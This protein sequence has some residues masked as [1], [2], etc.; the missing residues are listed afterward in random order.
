M[1]QERSLLRVILTEK[2]LTIS[3]GDHSNQGLILDGF[4]VCPVRDQ[5]KS[6]LDRSKN[7]DR[8]FSTWAEYGVLEDRHTVIDDVLDDRQAE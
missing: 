8:A 4:G 1:L 7:C 6:G 2:T 5:L 3:R